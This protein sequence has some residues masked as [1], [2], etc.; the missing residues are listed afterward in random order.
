MRESQAEREHVP[1]EA[2][3]VVELVKDDDDGSVLLG[4]TEN[5]TQSFVKL[6]LGNE[7]ASVTRFAMGSFSVPPKYDPIKKE[8]KYD[9]IHLAGR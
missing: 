8:P 6:G 2:A 9:P 7:V 3:K 1:V 4:R 5:G